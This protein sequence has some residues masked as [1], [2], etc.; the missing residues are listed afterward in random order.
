ME[1]HF[2][3]RWRWLVMNAM[4]GVMLAAAGGAAAD[5][6]TAVAAIPGER[7]AV[8]DLVYQGA[9]RLP[10]SFNW[11]ALG[12][13]FYPLGTGGGSLLVTGFQSLWD[14]A[15]PGEYCWDP[16]WDC[17]AYYGE[18]AIPTPLVATGWESLPEAQLVGTL[19]DFDHGLVAA[20]LSRDTT[21]VADL[22]YLPRRGSQTA[23]K[24]YGAAEPW[25]AEGEFGEDS[26]PTIWMADLDGSDV[27]GMF[28][29]GPE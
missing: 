12:V 8:S 24:L 17:R 19:V 21:F 4:V 5:P 11:G 20:T 25:Y 13:S 18:V 23:D 26:F 3:L 22:L 16:S 7:L 6:S 29:V 1:S 27:Q 2:V 15:H 28:H 14:P 10:D 9:F